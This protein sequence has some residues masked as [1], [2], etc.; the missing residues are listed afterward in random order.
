MSTRP[1]RSTHPARRPCRC[2]LLCLALA[3]LLT[4][5][6]PLL[7][8]ATAQSVLAGICTSRTAGLATGV[9]SSR[10]SALLAAQGAIA[11]GTQPTPSPDSPPPFG[12]QRLDCALCLVQV[13]AA[14]PPAQPVLAW[15][16]PHQASP[17]PFAFVQVPHSQRRPT[18]ARAPPSLL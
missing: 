11:V 3:W 7:R 2:V 5:A 14:P 17:A 1:A 10:V 15:Q 12:H 18:M 16:N 6:G 13:L 9:E 4:L 8:P